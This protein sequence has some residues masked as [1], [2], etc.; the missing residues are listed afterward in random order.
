MKVKSSSLGFSF[1]PVQFI[2][3]S[4]N[5]TWQVT[6]FYH[7][8]QSS[9]AE[10]VIPLHVLLQLPKAALASVISEPLASVISEP[11]SSSLPQISKLPHHS[12][13]SL[14]C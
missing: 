9:R 13:K 14:F 5:A 2:L 4:I 7:I 1:L 10:E 8:L 6:F 11:G 12:N 3:D